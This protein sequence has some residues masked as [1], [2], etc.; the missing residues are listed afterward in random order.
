MYGY[1]EVQ[2]YK[3]FWQHACE[4]KKRFMQ[5]ASFCT[6]AQLALNGSGI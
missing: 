4:L 6:C 1:C 2:Q 5:F 3:W